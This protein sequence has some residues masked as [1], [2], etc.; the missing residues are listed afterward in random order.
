[1]NSIELHKQMMETCYTTGQP[2]YA[3]IK[4]LIE[5]NKGV[6]QFVPEAVS[7][8]MK[9]ADI[10]KRF[11]RRD[12][13]STL[14]QNQASSLDGIL[15]LQETGARGRAQQNLNYSA[16]VAQRQNPPFPVSYDEKTNR[17]LERM[18]EHLREYQAKIA[19]RFASRSQMED[20]K[21]PFIQAERELVKLY[22]AAILK[23]DK[24]SN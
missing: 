7:D 3:A 20:Q 23:L 22:A 12:L 6:F 9:Q 19:S 16:Q 17:I 21:L 13:L 18:D 24:T 1:M 8:I 4:D 11:Q 5:K 14:I 15:K 10:A 2:N